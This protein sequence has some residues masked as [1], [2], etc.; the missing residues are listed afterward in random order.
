MRNDVATYVDT[1]SEAL[2]QVMTWSMHLHQ[3]KAFK[4]VDW[5]VLRRP[6]DTKCI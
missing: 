3:C 2:H 5:A 6:R 4:Q 1:L